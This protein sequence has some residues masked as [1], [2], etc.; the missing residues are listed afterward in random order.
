MTQEQSA[1]HHPDLSSP[2]DLSIQLVQSPEQIALLAPRWNDLLQSSCTNSLFSSPRYLSVWWQHFGGNS[3]LAIL[4]AERD[5][6]LLGIAPL[7]IRLG[8]SGPRRHLRHLCF[9][10]SMAHAEGLL[11]DFVV[12]RGWEGPVVQA[13][14]SA[15]SP[16]FRLHWDLL[17][18]PFPPSHSP[19]IQVLRDAPGPL[20]SRLTETPQE[21]S[22]IIEFKPTWEEFLAARS[23]KFRGNLRSSIRAMEEKVGAE[24]IYAGRELS[25]A[26]MHEHLTRF[27]SARWKD[28]RGG[29]PS[30][31]LLKF[32]R[33]LLETFHREGLLEFYGWRKGDEMIA[34]NCCFAHDQLLWGYQM[35]WNPDF[36][37]YSPGQ[38]AMASN[39]RHGIEKSYRGMNML[40]GGG[41]Y[42]SA[43]AASAIPL[44]R[45]EAIHLRSVK[46]NLFG[47]VKFAQ[48]NWKALRSKR[49]AHGSEEQVA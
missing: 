11:F 26:E 35:G 27:S 7:Q 31:E 1:A 43:W 2:Q 32:E 8:K 21:E 19:C 29:P 45:L 5:G 20:H 44:C 22:P 47:A 46:G 39:V 33:D 14:F 38:V 34:L 48:E 24:E 18:L 15:T 4:T 49:D 41:A 37:K 28:E 36:A 9:L 6:E 3:E 23:S 13:F 10:G 30:P 25:V 40:L 42:K 16:L 12:R 17:Y